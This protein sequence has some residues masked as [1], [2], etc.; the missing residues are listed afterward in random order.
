MS[1][2]LIGEALRALALPGLCYQDALSAVPP[3]PG[4]YAIH[5]SAEVWQ[6][7]GLGAPPDDRPLYVGKAERSFRAVT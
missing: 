3:R 2:L 1:E 6:Q 4:L 5:G 7:I